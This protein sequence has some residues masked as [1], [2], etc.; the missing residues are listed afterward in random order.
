MTASA[1]REA[2]TWWLG[3]LRSTLECSHRLGARERELRAIVAEAAQ[4]VSPVV[5]ASA[6][7]AAGV[8]SD[9]PSMTSIDRLASAEVARV[10]GTT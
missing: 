10:R 2:A 8:P 6:M 4:R 7:R 1:T 3:E 5:F 9:W